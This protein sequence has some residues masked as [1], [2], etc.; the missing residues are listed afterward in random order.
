MAVIRLPHVT[1]DLVISYNDPT[2]IATELE[3]SSTS[4]TNPD[5]ALEYFLTIA[6]SLVIKDWGLFN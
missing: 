4:D 2:M 6:K 5:K 1:T 3:S